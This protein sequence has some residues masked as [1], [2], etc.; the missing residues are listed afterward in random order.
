MYTAMHLRALCMHVQRLCCLMQHSGPLCISIAAGHVELK[1][2]RAGTKLT[3]N[4]ATWGVQLDR[5]VSIARTK[6]GRVSNSLTY[7]PQQKNTAAISSLKVSS[8][9]YCTAGSLKQA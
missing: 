2:T 1:Q 6:P 3:M 5:K 4:I 9:A 8:I 7:E